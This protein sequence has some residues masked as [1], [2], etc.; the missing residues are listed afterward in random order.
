MAMRCLRELFDG[1]IGFLFNFLVRPAH[2]NFN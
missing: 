2:K 1:W